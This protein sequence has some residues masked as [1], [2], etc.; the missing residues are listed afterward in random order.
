MAEV[1]R[2]AASLRFRGDDLDPDEISRILGAQPTRGVKK[3][4]M[5]K[6]PAGQEIVARTGSWGL[7]VPEESPGDLDKQVTILFAGLSKDL[8]AWRHL[9]SRFKA[10][11][12]AGV[13]LARRN[14][15][16]GVSPGTMIAIGSR[17]LL[18]ELDIYS[19]DD[20]EESE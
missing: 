8:D 17:G 6:T 3:G 15:G 13:F 20:D 5:W 1:D 18:L 10:D 11:I 9:A 7:R 12:F 19:G 2:T 16:L 4:G 14:E